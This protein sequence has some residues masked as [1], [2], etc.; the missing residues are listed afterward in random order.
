MRHK[1]R[2]PFLLV[3]LTVAVALGVIEVPNAAAADKS[4]AVN[5]I[6]GSPGGGW[7]TQSGVMSEVIKRALPPGSTIT[8]VPGS[9]GSN[10]R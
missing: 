6:S 8:I 4:M 10:R 1:K 3:M 7:Y 9:G 2:F 5:F